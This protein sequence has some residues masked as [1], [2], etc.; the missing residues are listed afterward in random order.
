MFEDE[1]YTLQCTVH[2]VAPVKNLIV[3]FYRDQTALGQ[4]QSSNTERTPVTEI[5][6]FNIIS[7]G[8]HDRAE[9]WC[10][11]ILDLG[12]EGPQPPPVTRS[13]SITAE[14]LHMMTDSGTPLNSFSTCF[15]LLSSALVLSEFPG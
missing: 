14:I 10:E 9:Y 12:T 7:T 3:N 4:R 5:F 11:A 15:M 8:E 13:Q 6:T 1:S 2:N